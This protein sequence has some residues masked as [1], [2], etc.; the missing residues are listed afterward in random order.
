[1]F[2]SCLEQMVFEIDKNF[3]P[4]EYLKWFRS[5]KALVIKIVHNTNYGY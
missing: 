3:P 4:A 1:M 5:T 2:K